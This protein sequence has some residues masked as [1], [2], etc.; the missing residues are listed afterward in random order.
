MLVRMQ[1]KGNTPGR[2]VNSCSH[3]GKQY[4]DVSKKLKIE[5]P[6]DLEVL[7]LGIYPKKRKIP[8]QK[9]YASLCSLQHYLQ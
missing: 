6:Y 4:G 2:N 3:Y 1:R 9:I 8:I 7:L 5:L